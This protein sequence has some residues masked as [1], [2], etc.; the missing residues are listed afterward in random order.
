MQS[1]A[2]CFERRYHGMETTKHALGGHLIE[3]DEPFQFPNA[4]NRSLPR[5][6]LQNVLTDTCKNNCSKL[7]IL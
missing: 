4:L 2:P 6:L 5:I 7:T 3:S 1:I